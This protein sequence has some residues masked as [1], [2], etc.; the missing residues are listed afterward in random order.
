MAQ[1]SSF[2]WNPC[3]WLHFPCLG[4]GNFSDLLPVSIMVRFSPK[5]LK[6]PVSC[7]VTINPQFLSCFKPETWEKFKPLLCSL[8]PLL[9][10]Q[11]FCQK[12]FSCCAS[13]QMWAGTS[14]PSLQGHFS[15]V[16]KWRGFWCSPQHPLNTTCP[17][18]CLQELL[19]FVYVTFR[20]QISILHQD[21]LIQTPGNS[22]TTLSTIYLEYVS[23]QTNPS[24]PS[25]LCGHKRIP[26]GYR[27][28]QLFCT[29]LSSGCLNLSCELDEI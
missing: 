23:P 25:V 20:A 24:W 2:P 26:R 9:L 13:P 21:Q 27:F 8:H 18:H 10:L 1:N 14:D 7:L 5:T 29:V 11:P 22:R 6:I 16:S 3:R 4:D 15:C 19:H 28:L 17:F 12:L